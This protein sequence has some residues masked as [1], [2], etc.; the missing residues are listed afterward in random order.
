MRLTDLSVK[1]LKAPNSGQKTFF[2]DAMP[3][4]GIRVSQ[5]GAK[6]FVVMYGTR[7][8]LKTLG[9]YPALSLSD[10]RKS[11]RRFFVE[12]EEQTVL[13]PA[14]PIAFTAARDRFL[15]DSAA[16]NKPGT[17]AEYHR[18]LHR[19][20]SYDRDLHEIDRRDI[21]QV[22][23]RLSRTPSEQKHAFV[24]IRTMMN[25]CVRHGFIDVSPVPP[26]PQAT[27][28]RDRILTDRELVAVFNRSQDYG[29]PFGPIV[30]LLIMTGQRRGEIAAIRREWLTDDLL[31]IPEGFAKNSREHR[32][33]LTAAV[34]KLIDDLPDLGGDL[35]FPSRNDNTRPFNGWSKCK[36]RFDEPL[37]I[38]P[39]TLHD[40]RRTFSSNMARL[41]TPI[42]VTEKMLNHVSGTLGGIAAVYNRYAY[43]DEM[44]RAFE[45]HD[46]FLAN[47]AAQ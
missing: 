12:A 21:M 16:R 13:A 10:A 32:V 22:V 43:L 8:R 37:G 38:A 39:Y 17:A 23:T 30:R 41:G 20:F 33:P 28:A 9:R 11:A 35:L 7:R 42:H 1:R 46:A 24:A 40:L 26:I 34:V 19:H 29:Y 18:L 47:L 6:S 3:G 4:F 2:D 44:R 27:T 31:T 5:G 45:A 36:A 15:K 14:E 25:W